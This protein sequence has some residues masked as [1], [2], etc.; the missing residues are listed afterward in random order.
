M[1]L[2]SLKISQFWH[3]FRG[4]GSESIFITSHS[5]LERDRALIRLANKLSP[6]FPH[7]MG[8][9]WIA[10]IESTGSSAAS[11]VIFAKEL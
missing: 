10:G 4:L 7:L 8:R 5:H 3:S 1:C 11:A 9:T 2:S 6:A